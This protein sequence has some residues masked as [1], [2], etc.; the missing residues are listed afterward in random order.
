MR[1][2]FSRLIMGICAGSLVSVAVARSCLWA[3]WA[4]GEAVCWMS[5]GQCRLIP[6]PEEERK[7]VLQV[8]KFPSI[9]LKQFFGSI[10]DCIQA[11]LPLWPHSS[12]VLWPSVP[13]QPSC[14]QCILVLLQCKQRDRLRPAKKQLVT[15]VPV[16]TV[17]LN[18]Y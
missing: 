8:L 5:S 11:D 18:P 6:S 2:G 17:Q 13:F 10:F 14:S 12:R 4:T 7:T 15:Q 9:C 16:H 1:W 3:A